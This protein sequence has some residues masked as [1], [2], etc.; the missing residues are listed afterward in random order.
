VTGHYSISLSLLLRYH[1]PSI[2][3]SFATVLLPY[4]SSLL[5]LSFA[6]ALLRYRSP[7]VPLSFATA[8][9]RY[10]SPSLPL[11]FATTIDYCFSLLLIAISVTIIALWWQKKNNSRLYESFPILVRSLIWVGCIITGYTVCLNFISTPNS[12]FPTTNLASGYLAFNVR[13]FFIVVG[14]NQDMSGLWKNKA[15]ALN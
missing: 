13:R 1:S 6:T 10:R 4:R 7:L 11:S 2:L 12:E 8:L 3:F 14:L 9:L 5:L 15:S